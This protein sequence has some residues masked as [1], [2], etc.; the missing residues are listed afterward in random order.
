MLELLLQ[1]SVVAHGH[2][3]EVVDGLHDLLVLGLQHVHRRQR[4]RHRR[5]RI[6]TAIPCVSAVTIAVGYTRL[7]VVVSHVDVLGV[8]VHCLHW[9]PATH[10]A[11]TA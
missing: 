8:G 10:T 5:D 2:V 9:L 7:G 1:L 11:H 4:R 3:E 6:L